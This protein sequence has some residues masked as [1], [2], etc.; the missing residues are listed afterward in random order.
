MIN[1]T[2]KILTQNISNVEDI[3][4]EF[5][6][7]IVNKEE[8][9]ELDIDSIELLIGEAIDRFTKTLVDMSGLILSN[10]NGNIQDENVRLKKRNQTKKITTLFGEITVVR[11]KYYDK[12]NDR[13]YGENDDILGLNRNHKL[14]KGVVEAIT[15]AS[16]LVPSFERAS[17][18]LDKLLHLNISTTQMQIVSEEIGKEVF[19]KQMEVANKTYEKPQEA[20]PH[21]LEKDRREGILYIMMDGSAVNTRIQKSC[22]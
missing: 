17:D 20:V 11:D 4:M 13:E 21:P 22:I 15:Y 16:Q 18:V 19:E 1:S 12:V 5:M 9:K 10:I 8:M 7:K 3:I 6:Q 2:N 14:T